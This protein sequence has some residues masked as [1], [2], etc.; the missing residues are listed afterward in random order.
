MLKNVCEIRV[1][2]ADTD[3]MKIVYN[4]KYPEY[5]EVGRCELLRS[6]GLP[7]KEIEKQGYQLPVLELYVKYFKP[8][9]YDDILEIEARLEKLPEAKTQIFYEI[10]RKENG[11]LCATGFTVHAFIKENEMKAVKPPEFYVEKLKPY[12]L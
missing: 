4:G 11:D 7:Y 1:R 12:F 8:A 5:F 2:Y 3:K 10:R 6:I 9:F